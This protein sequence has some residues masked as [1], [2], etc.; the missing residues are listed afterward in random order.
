MMLCDGH[1]VVAMVTTAPLRHDERYYFYLA[2]EPWCRRATLENLARG[3]S[4]FV[5]CKFA[6]FRSQNTDA[7]SGS[8]VLCTYHT[9]MTKSRHFH[10]PVLLLYYVWTKSTLQLRGLRG[11]HLA[12]MKWPDSTIYSSEVFCEAWQVKEPVCR[13]C[14]RKE[15]QGNILKQTLRAHLPDIALQKCI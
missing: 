12:V 6:T 7:L 11:L 2:F 8:R 3:C 10:E 5:P 13:L 1:P 9:A 14:L 15:A 4:F